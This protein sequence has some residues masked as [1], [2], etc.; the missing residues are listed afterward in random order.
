MGRFARRFR[1]GQFQHFRDSLG[2]E[3]GPPGFA[4]FVPQET[5]DAL[6]AISLLPTPDGGAT[7]PGPPR[8]LQNGQ[9]FGR[10]QDDLRPLYVLQRAIAIGRDGE[11]KLAVFRM[12]K[13]IDGLGHIAG[14]AHPPEFVNPMKASVH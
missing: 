7:D 11:Q 6:L 3:R 14:F 10:V 5:V 8:D 12:Q 2:R 9:S 1:A 13:N 4:R